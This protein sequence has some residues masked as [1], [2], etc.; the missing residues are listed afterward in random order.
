ML[1]EWAGLGFPSAEL[2]PALDAVCN[3]L[4]VNADHNLPSRRDEVMR[5]GLESLGWHVDAMPRAVQGCEQ[6]VVCGYCGYGCPLGAKQS[7]LRT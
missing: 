3:R 2:G 1:E 4:G 5:R 6:G 7:T